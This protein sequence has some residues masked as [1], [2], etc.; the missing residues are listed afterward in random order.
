[1]ND[2]ARVPDKARVN[3]TAQVDIGRDVMGLS[4]KR[5]EYLKHQLELAGDWIKVI[6]ALIHEK[7]RQR[8]SNELDKLIRLFVREELL[9]DALRHAIEAN[10]DTLALL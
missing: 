5:M 8:D 7:W 9:Q 10:K 6:D 4:D 1:M 3:D 2:T